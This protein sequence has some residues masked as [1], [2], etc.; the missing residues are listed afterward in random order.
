MRVEIVRRRGLAA[1]A[2][3]AACLV[4]PSV[5]AQILTTIAVDG[6]MAD[7]AAVLADPFQTAY[8]GPAAGLLDLDA[9]VPSTGRDLTTFAW[10]Y[11]ATHLY[12]YV[13]RVASSSNVQRFWF[14]IDTDDDDRMETGEP[15]VSVAWWGSNRRTLVELHAYVAADPGGDPLGDATGSADGWTMPG[16]VT[17][18]RTLEEMRGGAR[19]GIEMESRVAW[20][21]LA[22]AP[23]SP[24]RFH[25]ATSN[26]TNVPQQ[27]HDNMGGPGGAIGTTRFAGVRVTPPTLSATVSPG[28]DVPFAHTVENL[29]RAADRIELDWTVAGDFV[30]TAV[31]LWL[32]ADGDGVVGPGDTPLTDGDGDG[33]VDVFPVVPGGSFDIVL[34]ATIPADTADGDA[35]TITLTATS[36]TEP[37]ATDAALDTAIVARPAI[38]L[39]KTVSDATAAP[40]APLTYAVAYTSD[41]AVEAH[42]VVLVDPLP[43]EVAY[44]PGSATGPGT[45]IEFSHDGGATWDTSEAAPVTHIRWSLVAPLAPGDGGTVSFQASIR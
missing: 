22:V 17:P 7:W 45:L 42:A 14:Y 44:I 26:S 5:H 38:T 24:V 10:T 9:P 21:D 32:D 23:G 39:V 31:T 27:I 16:T 28:G 2:V 12:F 29:G 37:R 41:G 13:G 25:V 4:A 8:D 1:A 18:L 19:N 11:D 20:T 33:R 34:L 36:D 43:A 30:P 40:G 35:T 6:D 3:F 15:V